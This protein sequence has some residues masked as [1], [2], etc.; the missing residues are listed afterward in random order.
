[1]KAL[2][3]VDFEEEWRD[4]SSAYYLGDFKGKIANAKRLLIA[5]RAKGMMTIF[6]VHVEQNSKKEFSKG[7]KN[8]KVVNELKP[9]KGE[10][11]F[12][13]NK[14]SPFYKTGLEGYLKKHKIDEIIIAGIMTNLCVRSLASDAYDR[15]YKITIAK[16]ACVSNSARTDNFTLKD[17][18]N[19]RP[20]IQILKSKEIIAL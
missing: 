8:V 20:E 5:C 12:I 17:L 13:K 1:M 14:I 2:I 6:T 18:K 7:S 15:D 10:K 4:K 11:V 9:I 16:D 19:T 3:L